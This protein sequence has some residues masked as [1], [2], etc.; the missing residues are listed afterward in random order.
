VIKRSRDFIILSHVAVV[1][2]LM[3]YCR[4]VRKGWSPHTPGKCLS[5]GPLF[6]STAGVT[7]LCDLIAFSL[8]LTVLLP[9]RNLTRDRTRL[10]AFFFFGF[11]TTIC[12]IIR[13]TEVRTVVKNGDSTNLIL[14]GVIEACVGV[15]PLILLSTK[16]CR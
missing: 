11:F 4:P 15:P 12:S 5:P 10:V 13:M 14:W 6:Y 3:L 8:P 7:I 9:L 2:A 16:S 1:L